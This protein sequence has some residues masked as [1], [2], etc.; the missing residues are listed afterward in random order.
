L[1]AEGQIF[2]QLGDGPN[3]M[4]GGIVKDVERCLGV[5]D[6]GWDGAVVAG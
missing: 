5:D 3:A 6:Q 4:R 1:F 2:Q